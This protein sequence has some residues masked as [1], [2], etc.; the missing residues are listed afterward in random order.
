ML[1]VELGAE[2]VWTTWNVE[3]GALVLADM[4]ADVGAV[5]DVT[6]LGAAIGDSARWHLALV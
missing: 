5:L 2:L 3:M 4:L 6:G 1:V